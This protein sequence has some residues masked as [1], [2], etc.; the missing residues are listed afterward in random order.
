MGSKEFIDMTDWLPDRAACES[1]HRGAFVA[2]LDRLE[3]L[4]DGSLAGEAKALL[5]GKIADARA[6]CQMMCKSLVDGVV[7]GSLDGLFSHMRQRLYSISDSLVLTSASQ[8]AA[9]PRRLKAMARQDS[10][11]ADISALIADYKQVA[12]L[13]SDGLEPVEELCQIVDRQT[14][15][16]FDARQIFSSVVRDVALPATHRAFALGALCHNLV[17]RHNRAVAIELCR[18]LSTD[19]LEP[20]VYGRAA[21]A[22]AADLLA[23]PQR[24][25]DDAELLASLDGLSSADETAGAEL[26]RYAIVS[27]AMQRLAATVEHIFEVE[28]QDEMNILVKK[29]IDKNSSG[30]SINLSEDDAEEIFGLKGKKLLGSLAKIEEWKAKGVDVGFVSMKH[31]KTFPFFKGSIVNWLRPF[32]PADPVVADAVSSLDAKLRDYVANAISATTVL[33]DSD[34]Y[35]LLL[36]MKGMGDDTVREYCRILSAGADIASRYAEAHD[37]GSGLDA[38]AVLSVNS[39][40][41]DIYRAARLCPG[42]FGA[43]GIFNSQCEF[44]SSGLYSHLFSTSQLPTAGVR[45]VESRSWR[46]AQMVYSILCANDGADVGSLRKYAFCLLK[47]SDTEAALEQLRKADIVDDSDIWTKRMIAEC[48]ISLGRYA[49]AAYAIEQA[50]QIAPSDLRVVR[51]AARCNE[52]LRR[53]PSALSDWQSLAYKQP[54]DAEAAVGVARC[55]LFAGNAD[56]ASEALGRCPDGVETEKVKALLSVAQLKFSEAKESLV[57]LASEIG[58]DAAASCLTQAADSLSQYGV[59]LSHAFILADAVTDACRNAGIK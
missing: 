41:K 12:L 29:L 4:A 26:V 31:L 14:I 54:D 37:F 32:D 5:L 1:I 35:S 7:S 27:F 33:P 58:A 13:G 18:A 15:S 51:L 53:F 11:M 25:T 43:T 46:E 22:L 38:D 8:S 24:W 55:Q 36:G 19:G 50:R 17:S 42:D 30:G 49:Q 47:T 16:E 52:L 34:K 44:F 40:V 57:A 6:D 2:A 9:A 10:D 23:W 3:A 21:V 28:M 45:L 59:S 39:F 48:Y 20:F 56:G